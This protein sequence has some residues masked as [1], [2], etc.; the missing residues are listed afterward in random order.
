M[1]YLKSN[2]RLE[3]EKHGE[4]E[5]LKNYVASL[6]HKDFLGVLNYINYSLV[7]AWIRKNEKTYAVFAGILGTLTC[8]I[9]ELY[10]R[11]VADYEDA[12]ILENGDV[13]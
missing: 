2:L 3:L 9:Q 5:T 10:R 12:K 1:P 7:L 8:C 6:E 4:F 13:E 11:C